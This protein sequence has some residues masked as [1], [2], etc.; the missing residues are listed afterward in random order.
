MSAERAESSPSEPAARARGGFLKSFRSLENRNFRWYWFSG[1]GMAGAQGVTQFAITWLVLDLTGSVASLGLVILAQGFP[2][3]IVS[4]FGGV[5]ADR[6]DRRNLLIVAQAVSMISIFILAVL[7]VAGL[8]QLWLVF[9]NSIVFG[10]A[11]AMTGPARQAYISTLVE[12]EERINAI[13]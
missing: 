11:F 8:V 6:Y 3:T 9:A 5:L 2:M 4:L 13:A 1:L 12:P 7:T 10:F